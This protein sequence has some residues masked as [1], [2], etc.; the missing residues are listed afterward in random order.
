MGPQRWAECALK[1][2]AAAAHRAAVRW[3][4]RSAP[5]RSRMNAP[6]LSASRFESR[7]GQ[8]LL[9]EKRLSRDVVNLSSLLSTAKSPATRRAKRLRWIAIALVIYTITG[10]FIVPAIIKSQLV[11]RLPGL[12]HREAAVQQVKVNPYGLSL[13]IRGLSLT[14]T[15]GEPFAGFDEFY[16]NFELSSLFRW[17]WTFSEIRLAHPTGNIVRRGDG[18]FNFANL[19]SSEPAPTPKPAKQPKSLPV[20]L[21][22]HLVVTNGVFY[23]TDDTRTPPLGI[24][25]GPIN[26]YLKDFT[27]RRNK[28]RAYSL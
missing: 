2:E 16:I 15:N 24:N 6:G 3:Q 27:T 14:E 7:I 10:F 25:Y 28:N 13:T 21:I 22:Q 23:F 20:V 8:E 19:I 18:Q 4:F 9:I 26:L 12:N 5:G 17:A 1:F 11:K